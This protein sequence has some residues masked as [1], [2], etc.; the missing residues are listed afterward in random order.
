MRH[1]RIL[2]IDD[3]QSICQILSIILKKEAYIVDTASTAE[4]ALELLH[5]NSYDLILSDIKM[6]DM[7]GITL[8]KKIKDNEP[9]QMIIMMTAF[10]TLENAVEAMREGAYDYLSKPIKA[11]EIILHVK[12]AIERQSLL[13]EN[14][15]L[16]TIVQENFQFDNIIG[17]SSKIV[18]IFNTVR[19]IAAYKSAVLITGESGTGKEL[20]AKAIHF[21]SDRKNKPFIAVNC[22]AIPSELLESEL[23]GH[24]KGSFTGAHSNKIGLFEEANEGTL[25]L[26]EVADIQE[27]SQVKLLRALQ[28]DE[29]RPVG[30]NQTINVDVRII[31][32]TEQNL[33]NKIKENKFRESLFYRL[34]V[35]HIELPPLRERGMD[36]HLLVE[37]FIKKFAENNNINKPKIDSKAMDILMNYPWPGNVREL[38]N[39]VERTILLTNGPIITVEN[40]PEKLFNK[41]NNFNLTIPENQFDLKKIHKQISSILEQELIMRALKKTNYNRTHAA[42]LLK[43]SLRSLLYKLKEYGLDN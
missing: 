2:V 42:K 6:P 32:A 31:S 22:G 29:I 16:K 41:K 37:H 39:V 40:L 28:E 8:L 21:N 15:Y 23:F 10:G 18:K 19:K 38:E 3:E 25:F 33:E 27:I 20:F 36:I 24:K 5:N 35:V 43:I 30:S 9:E 12:K 17:K 14:I 7:D 1:E 34:N 4:N 13:R 26:D 11:K